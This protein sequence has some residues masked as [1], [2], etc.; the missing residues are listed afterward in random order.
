MKRYHRILTGI[1]LLA[2][3]IGCSAQ[4]TD[5]S[6]TSKEAPANPKVKIVL[7]WY[8][9]AEHGGFYAALVHGIYKSHGLDVEIVPG[10]KGV[11]VPPELELGR[12]QFGIG[13]ADDVLMA[14]SADSSMVA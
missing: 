1:G 6:P 7:N 5:S 14:R 13:N 4:K 2:L 8:P 3:L 11:S 9:E 10:G 12:A